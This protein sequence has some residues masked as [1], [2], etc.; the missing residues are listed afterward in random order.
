MNN[1]AQEETPGEKKMVFSALAFLFFLSFILFFFFFHKETQ[2]HP[3]ELLLLPINYSRQKSGSYHWAQVAGAG[4][5]A[6]SLVC[7]VCL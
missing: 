1:G 2:C 4:G 3:L 6:G 5:G 7:S